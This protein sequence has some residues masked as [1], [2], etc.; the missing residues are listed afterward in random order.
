M[1]LACCLVRNPRA[2]ESDSMTNRYT[3]VMQ[4]FSKVAEAG[5][6]LWRWRRTTSRRPMRL[7]RDL[8]YANLVW[9]MSGFSCHSS[10]STHIC[11]H[12]SVGQR[13]S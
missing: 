2:R 5:R 13:T 12:V 9:M 6:R 7:Q 8:F 11:A 4:A 3:S 1:D 10:F